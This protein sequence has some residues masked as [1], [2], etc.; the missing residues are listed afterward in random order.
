VEERNI[1]IRKISKVTLARSNMV[2]KDIKLSLLLLEPRPEMLHNKE[3]SSNL[4]QSTKTTNTSQD[5]VCH[6]VHPSPT[7]PEALRSLFNIMTTGSSMARDISEFVR[8][9]L[10]N[11]NNLIY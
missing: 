5:K 4:V 10:T 6:L 9:V 8:I 1:S 2:N 3:N 11:M 7:Q